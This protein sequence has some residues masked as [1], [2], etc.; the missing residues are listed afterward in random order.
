[1]AGVDALPSLEVGS[2]TVFLSR[3]IGDAMIWKGKPAGAGLAHG[4]VILLGEHTVVHGTPA[5]AVPI[6]ALTVT[7][8]A[9]C[10]DGPGANQVED[11]DPVM[12]V[13]REWGPAGNDAGRRLELVY[14]CAVPVARGLGA[15]AARAAAAVRAVA[16]LYGEVLGP[17]EVYE[18]VQRA[19]QVTHGRASGVDARAAVAAGPI[20]FCDGSVHPLSV[21][22]DAVLVLAD[23]G[24][25]GYTREAVTRVAAVLD[26]DPVWA[27]GVLAEAAGLVKAG[28]D[29]LV[30]GR[31][32]AL[33]QRMVAFQKVLA[34]L[35]VSTARI[36][37]MV[38]AA[39]DAGALGAKL[40]GGGLGGCVVAL[41][42]SVGQA[43]KVSTALEQVGA[44]RTWTVW[45]GR[46]P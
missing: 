31:S 14:D 16:D 1:M 10:A 46:T 38:E 37:Q 23:S 9:C 39:L 32:V 35:G 44:T 13:L 4:R 5:L 7:A 11:A 42:G 43:E 40:T 24:T 33:G 8:L 29:D 2:G 15:S 12:A 41:A 28:A 20:L 34:A 26:A 25:A 3:R 6:P 27:Q 22:L 17:E 21:G 45:L 19:E 18:L 30:T 36:D